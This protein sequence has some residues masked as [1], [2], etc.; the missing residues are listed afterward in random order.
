MEGMTGRFV[1]KIVVFGA[2]GNIG[3]YL[4][5]YLVTHV[6][7]NQYEIIATGRRKTDFFSRFGIRYIQVDITNEGSFDNLPKESIYAVINCAGILPAYSR[8]GG[9]FSYIDTNITGSLRILEYARKNQADRVIYTQTWAEL[10]GYWGESE[11]LR[12]EMVPKLKYTG[13]HAFYSITKNMVANSLEYYWQEYGLKRFIFRLPNVYMYGPQKSYYVNGEQ[14]RIGYR[15]LIDTISNGN[16][17]ELWGNPDAFK[18]I[19][20]IKDLCQMMYKAVFAEID[21]GIYNAGTGV[22]T[23]LKKQIEGMIE[24]FAPEGKKVNIVERPEKESFV[25]FVMDIDNIR[26]DLGYEPQYMYMD[27]LRDYKIEQKLKRFD[28]LMTRTKSSVS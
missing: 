14:R 10:A 2:T 17:V 20:Y 11:I 23:T 8:E 1:K 13:D 28:E 26:K 27:Y 6:D 9:I 25:S 21:G 22:R 18:D 4:T 7:K 3:A 15:Y 16:D 24:V 19:I 12:P 5:E